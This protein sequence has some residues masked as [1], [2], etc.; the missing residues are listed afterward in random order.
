[1]QSIDTYDLLLIISGIA[2]NKLFTMTIQLMTQIINL[3]LGSFTT[4]HE[5]GISPKFDFSFCDQPDH[6]TIIYFWN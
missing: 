6:Q 4:D 1:M 5:A 3:L 2:T